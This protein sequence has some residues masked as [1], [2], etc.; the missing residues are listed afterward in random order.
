MKNKFI[1]FLEKIEKI[2]YSN[3]NFLLRLV[4][5]IGLTS[6]V[7]DLTRPLLSN[8][9][10][11]MPNESLVINELNTF[12]SLNEIITLIILPIIFL[13]SISYWVI[14]KDSKKIPKS[15]KIRKI[16][17]IFFSISIGI[18][19]VLGLHTYFI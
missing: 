19:I 4:V 11:S 18:I 9:F 1:K 7:P 14:K 10:N 5:A 17:L 13:S 6:I 12:S 3:Y 8:Y 2:I 15:S 16:E